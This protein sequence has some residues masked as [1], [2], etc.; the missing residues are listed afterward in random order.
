M[1]L[2]NFTKST[3]ELRSNLILKGDQ[4][5][6]LFVSG[7]IIDSHQKEISLSLSSTPNQLSFSQF[8]TKAAETSGD[9]KIFLF[10]PETNLKTHTFGYYLRDQYLVIK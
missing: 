7:I 4:E 2:N 9:F 1:K 10:N 8:R 3:A 6:L 5:Q